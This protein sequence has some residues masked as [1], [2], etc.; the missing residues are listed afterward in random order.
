MAKKVSDSQIAGIKAHA[1]AKNKETL[2]KVNKAIDKLKRKGK[3]INF[4]TVSK[5]AGVS[6]AT[7]YNNDQLKERI[8]SLR[9]IAKSSP[10]DDIVAVKKDKIQLQDEKIV[11]LREQ[12]KKLEQDKKKLVAQLMDYEELKSENERLKK[13]L[14]T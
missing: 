3:P 1:E 9:A 12:V 6:R 8:L 4:E 14:N 5:E 11:T 2:D 13:R 7:L 10:L